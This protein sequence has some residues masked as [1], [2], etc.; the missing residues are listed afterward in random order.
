[1]QTA[2]RC[3]CRGVSDL[4]KASSVFH[5]DIIYLLPAAVR[6]KSD[7]VA[8][9]GLGGRQKERGRRRDSLPRHQ[10]VGH[11][12]H[13][14]PRTHDHHHEDRISLKKLATKGGS[15]P[16]LLGGGERKAPCP[17]ETSTHV[18]SVVLSCQQQQE[19]REEKRRSRGAQ[20]DL[21][22]CSTNSG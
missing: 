1:M 14:A 3:F 8:L 15:I 5:S 2:V 12:C 10:A 6:G 11:G 18:S 21:R 20:T 4:W 17:G 16:G 9:R 13:V 7:V 22:G 19:Q